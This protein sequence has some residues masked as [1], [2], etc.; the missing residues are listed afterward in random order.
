M[1]GNGEAALSRTI[2]ARRVAE[3]NVLL[4]ALNLSIQY[5]HRS[6][7]PAWAARLLSCRS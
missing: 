6:E 3:Q 5:G 7:F 4:V 1:S 2:V